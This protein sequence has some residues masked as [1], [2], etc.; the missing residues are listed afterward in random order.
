M[1][2]FYCRFLPGVAKTLQ[3][4]TAT[5]T[6]N[7]KVLSWLPHKDPAFAAALIT[8][9]PLGHPFPGAVLSLAMNTSDTHLRAVLQQQVGHHWQPLGLHSKKLSKT[10]NF[11]LP[12]QVSNIPLPS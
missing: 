11:L 6:G 12:S 3:L 2:N 8:A 5:L 1:I 7:P 9:V 4:L 10:E